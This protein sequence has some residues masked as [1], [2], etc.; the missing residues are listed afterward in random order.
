MGR[1][2]VKDIEGSDPESSAVPDRY[3]A[4]L[5]HK[6]AGKR[7]KRKYVKFDACGCK[8]SCGVEL[9]RC[10][11]EH[12]SRASDEE[13]MRPMMQA[14]SMRPLL[15][16]EPNGINAVAEDE[17][18]EIDV[19]VDSGATETVMAEDT[20]SGIIDIT[21]SLAC[22]RGVMYEVADG[23]QIPNLGERKFLG[24]TEDGRGRG[25]VA[26]VCAVNKSLMSVS[27]I[28]GKGNRVV[29]DDA[30]SYIE[31]NPESQTRQISIIRHE[32]V[33]LLRNLSTS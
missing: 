15:T 27:K 17:W 16:I 29:F 24:V 25:V 23:T 9:A 4:S 30:G 28:A 21:E 13:S 31:D 8:Q 3:P 7:H 32:S 33:Q 10:E 11:L 14:E 6:R 19:A 2:E 22:K 5:N 26:Q 1:P 12:R 18:V 20:L